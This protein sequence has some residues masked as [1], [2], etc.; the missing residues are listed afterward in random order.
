MRG[1]VPGTPRRGRARR[2][3]AASLLAPCLLGASGSGARVHAAHTPYVVV[4]HDSAPL[5]LGRDGVAR[6]FLKKAA[7]WPDG[8]PAS[9]VDL[10][11]AAPVRA[12]F[13]REV[14]GR[15]VASVRAYWQA[16]LF[17][18]RDTPPPEKPDELAVLAHVRATRGAVGYVARGTELPPGVH[19]LVVTP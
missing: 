16:E 2:L 15:S 3:A 14:L 1:S 6:L 10:P 13:S 18:G 8:T 12:A 5:A 7:H 17:Q 4:A 9:P 11:P 19:A